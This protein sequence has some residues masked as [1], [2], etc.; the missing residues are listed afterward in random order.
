MEPSAMPSQEI[1][2]AEEP[3]PRGQLLK[4]RASD[5][6]RVPRTGNGIHALCEAMKLNSGLTELDLRK[7]FLHPETAV[8]VAEMI[9]DNKRLRTLHV[10][11]NCFKQENCSAITSA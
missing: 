4:R 10:C 1:W 6:Q 2:H 7:N 11:E 8:L 9:I 5:V 3:S